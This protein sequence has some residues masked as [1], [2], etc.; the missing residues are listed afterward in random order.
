MAAPHPCA[1]HAASEREENTIMT[2]RLTLGQRLFLLVSLPLL[3]MVGYAALTAWAHWQEAVNMRR[4][5]ALIEVS[6]RSG[7][8]IHLM[9]VER[10]ASVTGDQALLAQARSAL[11]G[12]IRTMRASVD[13]L[14]DLTGDDHALARQELQALDTLATVRQGVDQ[15][16]LTSTQFIAQYTGLIEKLMNLATVGVQRATHADLTRQ[17]TAQLALLCEKEFAGR[18]RAQ[19]ATALTAGRL[20]DAA[21]RLLLEGVG[22]QQSCLTEFNALADPA[23]RDAYVAVSATPAYQ[24]AV[25]MR[26]KILTLGPGQSGIDKD[27]WFAAAT[28]RMEA[29]K[30]MLDTFSHAM[31]AQADG[32]KDAASQRALLSAGVALVA[33]L[34]VL[35][36]SMLT[37]RALRREVRALQAVM[38][39][40]SRQ[41]DLTHR[42][43]LPGE[44]EIA[45]IGRSF[46]Q[47][48]DAFARALGQVEHDARQLADAAGGLSSVSRQAAAGSAEQT[49]ASSQIAVSTEEISA[50]IT[51]V[52][53]S[54]NASEACAGETRRQASAGRDSMR[55]AAAEITE[56]ADAVQQA[57]G[58]IHQL[59]ERSQ[60]ISQLIGSIQG[61][62]DQTNLL[63]L[64]AS[65]EAARAGEQGRGFAV[66]ADEVRNLAERTSQATGEI[67]RLIEAICQDTQGTVDGMREVSQRMQDG[68]ARLEDTQ[69]VLAHIETTAEDTLEKAT[70]ISHAMREHSQASHDVAEN[71]ARIASH[72]QENSALIGEASRIA[73]TMNGTAQELN[74]LVGRFVLPRNGA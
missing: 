27:T 65:I 15:H 22:R 49:H 40:T 33:I 16:S 6:T 23:L 35:T 63:A 21:R 67:T 18:E 5:A 34:L 71:V 54:A 69:Q 55:Q 45:S 11:D 28:S 9:Q 51:Q 13:S 39:N 64:N 17:M 56:M 7:D 1:A 44:D 14:D 58:T 66:V 30:G 2:H 36:L 42:A 68:L 37:M 72:A 29:I 50:G 48:V 26:E 19:L 32:L 41:L 4:A 31:I 61:I 24:D 43:N 3:G 74:A 53:D 20:D 12:V 46:D 57:S 47:L 59:H 25:N 10:G 62:A 73:Q 70:S 52:V 38:D 60:A 8:V